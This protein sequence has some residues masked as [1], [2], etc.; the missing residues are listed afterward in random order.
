VTYT[1]ADFTPGESIIRAKFGELL[2]TTDL[3]FNTEETAPGC[4]SEENDPECAALL[5]RMGVDDADS[6]LLFATD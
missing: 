2:A 3:A 5:P 6:Q 1:L 4:M